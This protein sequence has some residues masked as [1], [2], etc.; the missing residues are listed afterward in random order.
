MLSFVFTLAAMMT[1]FDIE[2]NTFFVLTFILIGIFTFYFSNLTV[3]FLVFSGI[4]NSMLS[5][6]FA[7][8]ASYQSLYTQAATFGQ[9]VSGAI[10]SVVQIIL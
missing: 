1:H 9:G 5:A 7:L 2:P 4:A 3:I 8:M 10:P 6:V